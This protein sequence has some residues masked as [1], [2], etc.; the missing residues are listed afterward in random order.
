M[1]CFVVA[2]DGW[3]AW[4]EQHNQSCLAYRSEDVHIIDEMPN[5]MM[6]AAATG[7]WYN[8]DGREYQTLEENVPGMEENSMPRP[9]NGSRR[10]WI[11]LLSA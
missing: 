8:G 10:L 4:H 5:K 3:W 7:S 1:Q 11:S 2:K 9:L 6:T